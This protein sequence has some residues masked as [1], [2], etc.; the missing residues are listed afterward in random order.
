M[1][2]CRSLLFIE[3]QMIMYELFYISIQS[4]E[5]DLEQTVVSLRLCTHCCRINANERLFIPTNLVY[6]IGIKSWSVD[7]V[8]CANEYRRWKCE[9]YH[10]NT[11]IPQRESLH[12]D[13]IILP[14]DIYCCLWFNEF[15][16]RDYSL[17]NIN[18]RDTYTL[19][20]HKSTNIL[21]TW[22]N[23]IYTCAILIM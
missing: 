7:R 17:M 19:C 10:F 2:R 5:R 14:T 15:R 11:R 20:P 9:I 8:K 16:I 3:T 18:Y 4:F 23:T 6:V 21:M 12:D 22:H 13:R 1:T